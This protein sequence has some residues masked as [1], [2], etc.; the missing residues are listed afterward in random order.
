MPA[1]SAPR[2]PA[3]GDAAVAVGAAAFV[4]ATVTVA[5]RFQPAARA[6]DLFAYLWLVAAAAPLLLMRRTPIA[7]FGVSSVLT[8]AYYWSGYP[9]GPV[10]VLPALCLLTLTVRRGPVSGAV[11]GAGL[12][13]GLYVV[14]LAVM[15]G[16]LPDQRAAAIVAGVAAVVGI[17]TAI[18]NRRAALR[19]ADEQRLEQAGRLAEQERLRIAR[20]V[21]D[22]VAHSLAMI[23]VQAGVAAHVADR[24]PEQAR[25]AL[26]NIKHASASALSDLR[27][28]LSVLRSG[29]D[30]APMPGLD[31]LAELLDHA[32]AAGLA[33]RVHGAAAGLPAPVDGA[34]YRILQESLTNVVRHANSASTVDVHFGRGVQGLEIIVRDDGMGPAKPR[35]GNGLR[36]MRERAEALGGRLHAGPAESGN[37][38]EVRATLPMA[39]T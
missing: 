9:G 32:R 7:A 35:H 1:R 12:L 19:A 18:R 39:E 17:G 25:E 10:I 8:C 3:A 16:W 13:L 4:T 14:Y 2:V 37:G 21:H 29:E 22:V 15:P 31:Q 27:A 20:E 34:A 23:N 38:F 36:G 30:K 6:L 28:T 24:R 26:Q 33:V 5:A 11:A